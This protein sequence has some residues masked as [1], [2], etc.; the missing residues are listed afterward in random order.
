MR[1][2]VEYWRTHACPALRTNR[3][4][5]G[6]CGFAGL[7]RITSRVEQVR[8]R[9][10]RHR[11]AGMAGVRLLHRVHRQRPDRVDGELFDL[12]VGQALLLAVASRERNGYAV[13]AAPALISSLSAASASS[14]RPVATAATSPRPAQEPVARRGRRRSRLRARSSSWPGGVA[15]ELEAPA[16]L[17]GEERRDGVVARV[18][19]RRGCWPSVVPW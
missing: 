8:E 16:E 3:S 13:A 4:R 15:E 19:R 17:L 7:C 14:S 10:E 18:R 2:S 1:W 5:S 12:R 11:R 6:Q 9:R